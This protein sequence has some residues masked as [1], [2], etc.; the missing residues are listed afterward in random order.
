MTNP[1]GQPRIIIVNFDGLRPDLVGPATTPHLDRLKRNGVTLAR[2]RTVYPSETR[3]ALPSLVTGTPPG[4]HGMVGN[5][6]LD[7]TA[8]P[9]RYIDTADDRLIEAV[10]AASGGCLMAVSS[11]GEIL[12]AHGRTLAV[13]ASNSAGATCLLNHKARS[14]G[15]HTISGHYARICTS[16]PLLETLQAQLGPLPTPPPPGRPDLT[17]QSF[18]TSALLNTVWPQLQPDVAILSYAEPDISSHDYGVAGTRTLDALAWVD[19]QFGRVLEWWETE[20][21]QKNVHLIALSDH[22]HV[23]VHSHADPHETLKAAGLQC[24]PAPGPDVD[25]VVVPGQ[26]GAI[27]LVNPSE[28]NIRRAV[29]AMIEAPWCGP[30]FTAARNDVDGI[31]PGSLARELVMMDH[32]RS[33]DILFS[34]RSDDRTDPFGLVGGTWSND[35]PIGCG[36]HGGLHPKEMASLGI[37]AGR[38]F[39]SDSVSEIPSGICDVA[40]TVLNLLGIATPNWMQGRVLTETFAARGVGRP[41]IAETT[42]VVS[43]SIYRQI[44]RCVQVETATYIEGGW[45]NCD[46]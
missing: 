6:Y 4:R 34:Y 22:G 8:A 18:L 45:A 26:V 27:Y 24:G 32:V 3:V 38:A 1:V 41:S 9:A 33:A 30:I 43:T 39:R 25:T 29:A 40:P 2:Q 16:R 5:K 42:Y 11:L 46:L 23:T 44:L 31:A 19:H 21:R 7:R 17:S 12:A 13:L 20:G 15:H 10:D 14:L 36:V 28:R 35:A 37:V